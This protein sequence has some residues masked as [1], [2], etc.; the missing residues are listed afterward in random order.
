MSIVRNDLDL[1]GTARVLGVSP[2]SCP[3]EDRKLNKIRLNI[4]REKKTPKNKKK[5]LNGYD[6]I[7]CKS[8]KSERYGLLVANV[9]SGDSASIPNKQSPLDKMTDERSG[10]SSTKKEVRMMQVG[11]LSLAVASPVL[12][13]TR[14]FLRNQT[15]HTHRRVHHDSIF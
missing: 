9:T 2:P 11:C 12:V 6:H 4:D 13:L 5:S 8:A 1:S 7:S 15:M 3:K 10:L 14:L